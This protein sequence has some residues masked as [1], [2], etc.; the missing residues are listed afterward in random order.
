[1]E[2]IDLHCDLLTYLHKDHPT[3]T[4]HDGHEIGAALPHLVAGN[5]K[6][7]VMAIFAL[8]N[9]GSVD[10]GRGQVTKFVELAEGEHFEIIADKDLA[11]DLKR[12]KIGMTAAIESASVLCEEEGSVRNALQRLAEII[13]ACKRL[14]YIGFTHHTENRFG[15][16]NYSDNVG[17]KKDG[18]ALLEFMSGKSIAIDFSH[19]SDQLIIDA[20]NHIDQQNLEV[21]VIASH[22]NFRKHWNHVR[23]L[24][25]ELAQEIIH[26]KGLIGMNFLRNYIHETEPKHL[27]K[28]I[29]YGLNE[30]DENAI[31]LG[32]DYFDT[33]A[34]TA[35]ER[36]PLFFDEHQDA[37]KYPQILSEL[38][39]NGIGQDKLAKLSN[40][41]VLNFI[42][43]NWD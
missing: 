20:L 1:M 5:V 3:A 35:P 4:I 21:P 42:N 25:D 17:L 28:H 39:A 33:K 22:S 26:R 32:A 7:Q 11:Q 29:D 40:Q 30:L 36:Q 9:P 19:A 10:F 37:S 12:E 13:R 2:I 16:G 8:T 41:N 34:I 27:L 31:A 6:H 14:F 23:N 43:R 38:K 15:G 18:K 24:P